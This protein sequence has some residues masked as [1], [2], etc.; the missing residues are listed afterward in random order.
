MMKVRILDR[1][2]ICKIEKLLPECALGVVV[3]MIFIL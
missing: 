1:C 2:N 3:Y